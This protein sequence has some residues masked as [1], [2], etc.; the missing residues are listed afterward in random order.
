MQYIYITNYGYTFIITCFIL[1]LYYCV[2]I[3]MAYIKN[4]KNRKCP[5]P[6]FLFNAILG[7]LNEFIVLWLCNGESPVCLAQNEIMQNNQIPYDIPEAFRYLLI[8][9]SYCNSI[10]I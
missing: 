2:L 5:A 6:F 3:C 7:M 10:K 8:V 1:T 9:F 4:S